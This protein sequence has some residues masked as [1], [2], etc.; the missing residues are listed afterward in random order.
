[1]ARQG[2]YLLSP[3]AYT[4]L[5]YLCI[6]FALLATAYFFWEA[7]RQTKRRIQEYYDAQGGGG[8]EETATVVVGIRDSTTIDID[9]DS[10]INHHSGGKRIKRSEYWPV[11]L[12]QTFLFAGYNV[13]LFASV[14]SKYL[15]TIP[16]FVTILLPFVLLKM[17]SCGM[18]RR[19]PPPIRETSNNNSADTR[20]ISDA[21]LC[22]TFSTM[23]GLLGFFFGIQFLLYMSKRCLV[24]AAPLA[25]YDYYGPVRV[26]GYSNS[27]IGQDG[28]SNLTPSLRNHFFGC[29]VDEAVGHI[30]VAWG[31]A[32]ACHSKKQ[33]LGTVHSYVCDFSSCSTCGSG[34][35][36]EEEYERTLGASNRCVQGTLK[37]DHFEASWNLLAQNISYDPKVHPD[38]D[39]VPWTTVLMYADCDTCEAAHAE[40]V[41]QQKHPGG[42][43]GGVGIFLAVTFG[44]CVLLHIWT[45]TVAA[46]KRKSVVNDDDD[47][48]DEVSAMVVDDNTTTEEEHRLAASQYPIVT[49]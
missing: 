38:H 29:P 11:A 20:L 30:Q 15:D 31:G 17:S 49:Y 45:T 47:D 24:V 9:I 16:F 26:V 33:C 8:V 41:E 46:R 34:W 40:I 3:T 37:H 6:A 10:E 42:D 36:S 25:H 43:T 2:L 19:Y 4:V 13:F 44:V 28:R 22:S 5:G 14:H 35:C 12:W 39:T 32:W 48:D 27:T 1:M 18:N 21:R 7:L 23:F